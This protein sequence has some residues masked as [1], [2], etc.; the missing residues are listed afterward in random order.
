MIFLSGWSL[1]PGWPLIRVVFHQSCLTRVVS[2][3]GYFSPGWSLT[4]VVSHQG[5]FS[6]GWSLTRVVSHQGYFSPGWSLTRVVSHQGGF[7]PGWSLIRVVSVSIK[8]VCCYFSE[9]ILWPRHSQKWRSIM[10]C[11]R[12]FFNRNV[13]T[14]GREN[15]FNT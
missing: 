3:Q 9:W 2:H 4:R 11:E 5:G 15:H 8:W 12:Q 7:S 6:P 1:S 10:G 13:H 14:R